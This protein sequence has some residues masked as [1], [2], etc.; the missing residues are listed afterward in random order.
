MSTLVHPVLGV[1]ATYRTPGNY[2]EVVFAQ[3]P[4]SAAAGV[5]EV[6]FVMPKVSTGTWT[7]GTLYPVRNE[8][9]AEDGGG[10]GSPIHRGIRKFLKVNKDAKVW[11]LPVS[12]TSG[13]SPIA[14]TWVLT[15]AT[16]ASG[17]GTLSVTIAGELCQYTFASGDTPTQI[18]DGIVAAINAKTWLPVTAANA[19]GTVT[20]T[21]KLKGTSQGTATLGVIRAR[22]E[23]TSGVGT[24]ASAGGAFLG[25][26]AAG[27]EG[28]T[29]EAANITTA[30]AALDAVRK[31]YI[32][33]SGNT[34]TVLG[35]FKT[36]ITTK[37]EPKRGLRSVCISAYTGSLA[38][39][40]T[41]ATGL[42]YE[43]LQVAWQPNSEHD[44]AEI[45]GAIAAIR[46]K[47]EQLDPSYNFNST[48][49][50]GILLPAYSTADWP[51][52]DDIEDAIIDGLTPIKSDDFGASLVQSNT[53][54]S[55]NAAGTVSDSRV[56][57][58]NKVSTP[59][60]FT[61][62]LLV[63]YANNYGN[64]KFKDDERLADGSINPNQR[65][66][67]DVVRPSMIKSSIT[68]LM[69]EYN[70]A[71]QVQELPAMK[72]SISVVK[73]PA[74]GGRAESAFDFHTIDWLDQ[75]TTRVAEVSTG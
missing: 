54:R 34:S 13:G 59:D 44:C 7:A 46:Q 38:T 33:T 28:S 1:D 47:Q 30:L 64:K 6:V 31:Y 42:N 12:E 55:K 11:A 50:N 58:T 9:T 69:D 40:Q 32:V 45:A 66:I 27:V 29:T 43:R 67:R 56:A 21:A 61:D 57:R 24:T 5:R 49:L 39:G 4:S 72:A 68:Q 35:L 22:A 63:R 2:A 53:T 25:S 16:N 17:T 19:S 14:A 36:H 74:A 18:G 65:L 70:D 37:S 51:D 52:G 41:L 60:K 15:L 20:V 8:K 75:I 73:S 23:I 48:S 62:D 10:A 3:G 26:G 71:G